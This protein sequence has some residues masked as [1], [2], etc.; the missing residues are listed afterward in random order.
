[1][2]LPPRKISVLVVLFCALCAGAVTVWLYRGASRQLAA[3]AERLTLGT[4]HQIYTCLILVAEDQG[5]FARQGLDVI[6][7]HYDYGVLAIRDLLAGNVDVAVAA[8]VAVA[9]NVLR[10]EDIRVLDTIDSADILRLVARTDRGIRKWRDWVGKKVG[11]TTGTVTEFFLD[12]ALTFNELSRDDVELVHLEPSRSVEALK[13]DEVDAI[14]VWSPLHE[15]AHEE[16]GPGVMS[17]SV[18]YGQDYRQ[19]L[20]CKSELPRKRPRAVEGLLAALAYSEDFVASNQGEA[21]RI[22]AKRQGEHPREIDRMWHSHNFRLSLDQ[23]LVLAMEDAAK[24]QVL[25]GSVKEKIPN[26]LNFIYPDGLKAAKPEA[27]SVIH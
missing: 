23:Q 10:G 7:K 27:V 11:L 16:L 6:N 15:S 14:V 1:M 26:F 18:Q 5:F 17:W 12:A 20:V 24:W 8:D 25:K 22:V 2:R 9:W 3:P 21:K 4:Y 13:N 19:V